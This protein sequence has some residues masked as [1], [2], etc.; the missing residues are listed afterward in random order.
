ME[1][2][3]PMKDGGN[4]T[5]ITPGEA[6]E[7]SVLTVGVQF[8]FCLCHSPVPKLGV[9]MDAALEYKRVAARIEHRYR[10]TSHSRFRGLH[11]VRPLL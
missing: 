5:T 11:F 4:L 2:S 6:C 10:Q 8:G 1:V 3:S 7:K 9:R